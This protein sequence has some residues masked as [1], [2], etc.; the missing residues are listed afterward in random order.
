MICFALATVQ[1][2]DG[3]VCAVPSGKNGRKREAFP[4]NEGL[5][6]FH[7]SD[8]P[9]DVDLVIS[10]FIL[11]VESRFATQ[12]RRLRKFPPTQQ[13]LNP[14]PNTQLT[15][16][17]LPAASVVGRVAV[18]NKM[19]RSSLVTILVEVSNAKSSTPRI[20]N[21]KP[22]HGTSVPLGGASSLFP[23]SQAQSA[24]ACEYGRL[25]LQ[26]TQGQ[27]ARAQDGP[28]GA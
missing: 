16:G 9:A 14:S 5:L 4:R 25:E 2:E 28:Q 8:G 19:S 3:A 12:N 22:Q 27:S 11:P 10:M 6:F 15:A 24:P 21:S 18:P 13:R 26:Y 17:T 1:M 23:V 20:L 7:L